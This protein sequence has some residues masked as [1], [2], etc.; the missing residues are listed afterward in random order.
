MIILRDLYKTYITIQHDSAIK[1]L[2]KLGF[3]YIFFSLMK[4]IFSKVTV[5]L[6]PNC[7][8]LILQKT[9]QR[10]ICNLV[11]DKVRFISNI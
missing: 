5:H 4:G 1:I 8:I 10:I 7:A 11:S 2:N 9:L 6:I 3:K